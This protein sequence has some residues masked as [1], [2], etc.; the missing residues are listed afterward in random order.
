M[1]LV[2]GSVRLLFSLLRNPMEWHP[3]KK[4]TSIVFQVLGQRLEKPWQTA[5]TAGGELS[6]WR[7]LRQISAS[8]QP[9]T[10]TSLLEIPFTYATAYDRVN[11]II[12]HLGAPRVQSQ[13]HTKLNRRK[14]YREE[15]KGRHKLLNYDGYAIPSNSKNAISGNNGKVA[16]ICS[17]S[18]Q[19]VYTVLW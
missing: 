3:R 16:L 1:E 11:C 9:N 2:G 13:M 15:K 19:I 6:L 5:I 4:I 14:V 7:V 10:D 12:T 8:H 17:L 18:I